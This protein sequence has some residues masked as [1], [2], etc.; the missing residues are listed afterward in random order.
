MS[1]AVE[2]T[3]HAEQ[4]PHIPFLHR[5]FAETKYCMRA[6]LSCCPMKLARLVRIIWQLEASRGW[7]RMQVV[8]T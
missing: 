7:S 6:L 4:F 8:H 1:S 5:I 2:L 3:T